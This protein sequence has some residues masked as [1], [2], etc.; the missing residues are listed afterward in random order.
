VNE[1][2]TI[3]VY[4]S[5]NPGREDDGLGVRFAEWVADRRFPG[6]SVDSN[7]QLNVEDALTISRYDIVVFA[8]ASASKIRDFRLSVLEPAAQI[9]FTTHAMAPGSVL[10]LC[11][12]LYEEYPASFLLEIPGCRWGFA[13]GLSPPAEKRLTRACE[14]MAPLFEKGQVSLFRKAARYRSG[15]PRNPIRDAH[16]PYVRR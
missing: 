15:R 2:R 7:Y 11:H 13:E 5:G 6:V 4:G 1:P 8:D 10:G 3:L 14:F 12:D 9:A 16:V